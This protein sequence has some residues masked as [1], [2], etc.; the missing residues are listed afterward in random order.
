MES[1]INKFPVN[2]FVFTAY[3]KSGGVLKQRTAT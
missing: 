1:L 2:V 3:S